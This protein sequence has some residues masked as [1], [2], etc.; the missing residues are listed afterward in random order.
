MCTGTHPF[1]PAAQTAKLEL[2]YLVSGQICENVLFVKNPSGWDIEALGTLISEAHD[3]WHSTLALATSSDVRLL[4]VRAKSLDA[5][6][7]AGTEFNPTVNNVGLVESP[8]APLNV[9]LATKFSTGLI[10]RSFRG[11]AYFVGIPV[12]ELDNNT[13]V[14]G[15]ADGISTKWD[16]FFLA[17]QTGVPDTQHVVV[18]Y[19]HNNAWRT[20]AVTTPVIHYSTEPYIDSQR[21]RLTGRGD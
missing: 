2:V 16:D 18:S 6:D 4:T 20:D 7:G 19:C 5:E 3:A 21:R 9:T 15:Y 17:I 12:N 10:G 14:G 8:A 11:R 1:I 13:V